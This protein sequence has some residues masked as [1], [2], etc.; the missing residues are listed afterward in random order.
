MNPIIWRKSVRG[1]KW[2]GFSQ[3]G[4]RVM[5]AR[6]LWRGPDRHSHRGADP[7]PDTPAGERSPIHSQSLGPSGDKST[8][9]WQRKT[10]LSNR[11]SKAKSLTLKYGDS[12]SQ[13]W[14]PQFC[15]QR[16]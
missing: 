9:P 6:G 1:E 14:K 2:R 7:A 3:V 11:W 12:H 16:C 8:L 4:S 5:Q 15:H 13:I 10:G